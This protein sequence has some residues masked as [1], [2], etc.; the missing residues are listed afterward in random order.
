MFAQS[1]GEFVV[2][3]DSDLSHHPKFIPKFVEAQKSDD[4]DIV[5]GSRYSLL[6]RSFKFA[7]KLV[8]NGG[9]YGWNLKRKCFST[10]ANIFAKVL[11]GTR[12]SDLTGSFRLYRRKTFSDL[13]KNVKS[14]NF[15]F[16]ME[17]M[18]RAEHSNFKI[19]EV[20][21]TFVDRIYGHSKLGIGEIVNYIKKVIELSVID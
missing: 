4:Y 18:A 1:K 9:V 13:L 2:I 21:I 5:S 10:I 15:N 19:K 6:P 11:L 3:M 7:K 16:Q 12:S 14:L 20:P 17:I 8:E